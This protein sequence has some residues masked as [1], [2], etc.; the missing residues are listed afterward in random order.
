MA[1]EELALRGPRYK[2]RTGQRFGHLSVEADVGRTSKGGVLWRCKCDCGQVTSV[3][4]SNL[5]NGHTQSCGCLRNA[6]L[7]EDQLAR[8]RT[9]GMTRSPEYLS[10]VAMIQRCTNANHEAFKSYGGRGIKVC[11]RWRDSFEAFLADMGPRPS[12]EHSLDRHPDKDGGYEP[13]NVRWATYRQQ[14]R[15]TKANRLIE[16]GGVARPLSEWCEIH[17]MPYHTVRQ[18]LVRGWDAETA[19][20]KKV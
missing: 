14:N 20:Q 10:W 5:Q 6:S 18:R 16:I 9:H 13:G 17:S 11:D 19:L 4:S 3:A 12:L 8:R 15:N 1:H 2:D 7:N